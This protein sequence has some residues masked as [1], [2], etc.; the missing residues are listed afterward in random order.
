[1]WCLPPCEADVPG[2]LGPRSASTTH[3]I[4]TEPRWRP[5]PLVASPMW[6]SNGTPDRV[7]GS[8]TL[9]M[10]LLDRGERAVSLDS[11][12]SLLTSQ[13]FGGSQYL[14]D[15]TQSIIR[16]RHLQLVKIT[17]CSAQ[18]VSSSCHSDRLD[19]GCY[20]C[21]CWCGSTQW[22]GIYEYQVV[23]AGQ[24][25]ARTTSCV[26]GSDGP[27]HILRGQVAT[28]SMACSTIHKHAY[29]SYILFV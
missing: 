13:R 4:S 20:C 23:T 6:V 25:Y 3:R 28:M 5:S 19:A 8:W 12:G 16:F 17:E 22:T 11:R 21:C 26:T 29:M 27:L 1:M 9:G 10:L 18:T 2:V 24:P 14:I 7:A 15:I